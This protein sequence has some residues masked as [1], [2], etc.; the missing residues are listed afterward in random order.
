MSFF[1]EAGGRLVFEALADFVL[2]FAE[3]GIQQRRRFHFDFRG[4]NQFFV[5]KSGKQQPQQILRDGR[6]G[7]LGRQVFAVQM[8]DAAHLGVGRDELVRELRDGFHGAETTT[9]APRH[10][11]FV[12]WCFG[13]SIDNLFFRRA[14]YFAELL[15]LP[16]SFQQST[17]GIFRFGQNHR[18]P[19]SASATAPSQVLARPIQSL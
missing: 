3:D 8:I 19:S 4:M 11:D 6:D 15:R 7:A 5:K 1:G 9:K 18:L 17:T 13:G 12:P 10:K 14:E 2:Q 16:G